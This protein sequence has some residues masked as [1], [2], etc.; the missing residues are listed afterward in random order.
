MA[1][2][3]WLENSAVTVSTLIE[4]LSQQCRDQVSKR[5]VLAISDTSEI[6]LQAHAGR[7]KDE[8]LGVVGNDTDL[9]FFIHPT[10]VVDSADG[11]PLGLST[12][13]VWTRPAD[14]PRKDER[15]Y[16]N[17]PIE[18]KES[19][20]WIESAR[21][22]RLCFELGDAQQVTYVG[23]SESDIYEPWIQV[24][25]PNVHLLIRA[26]HNRLIADS[27][28]L[29]FE[30]LSAQ[31]IS[32]HYTLPV[33]AEPRINRTAREA[34][35]AVRLTPVRLQCTKR[36]KGD[37]PDQVQVYAVEA[38]ELDPPPGQKPVHWRLLTTHQ[39]DTYLDALQII[40]WYRWRWHI[41]QLFA[42]LKQRGLDIEASQQ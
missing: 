16:K 7:L 23:D 17:Q 27:D 3:R 1:Y 5:H 11:L 42:I 39:V 37:Y 19:Y 35:M 4:S 32:G 30:Y 2:Y 21:G 6:N 10:L 24:P 41:E 12:V 36:L 25:E 22:S 8:G 18:E 38:M 9:G 20:K 26:C 33:P 15:D 14:R 28:Q 34:T 13:Q 40:Q 29:L 31:P